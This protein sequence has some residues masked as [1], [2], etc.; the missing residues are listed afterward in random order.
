MFFSWLIRRVYAQGI[1]ERLPVAYRDNQVSACTSSERL[2]T[3]CPC[4]R[5]EVGLVARHELHLTLKAG[6]HVGGRHG[7]A[8]TVEGKYR[9]PAVGWYRS[10]FA[11]QSSRMRRYSPNEPVIVPSVFEPAGEVNSTRAP[12]RAGTPYV[13]RI[14]LR[15]T[16]APLVR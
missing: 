6:T 1:P 9:I 8:S 12:R 11:L 3:E 13:L 4:A 5:F 16:S 2:R 15:L 14:C 7:F 10:A